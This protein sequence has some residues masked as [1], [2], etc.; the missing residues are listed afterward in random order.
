MTIL[1]LV[2]MIIAPGL[3][4]QRL[5]TARTG[6]QPAG[7]GDPLHGGGAGGECGISGRPIGHIGNCRFSAISALTFGNSLCDVAL[8][9][10]FGYYV[11]ADPSVA[12]TLRKIDIPVED[13]KERCMLTR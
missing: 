11:S 7:G 3:A 13:I 9:M 10:P 8:F 12:L 2:K 1:P 6:R 5:T 4:L